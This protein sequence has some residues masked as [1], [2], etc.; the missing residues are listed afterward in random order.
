MTS[1]AARSA[2]ALLASSHRRQ[3]GDR[4]RPRRRRPVASGRAVDRLVNLQEVGGEAKPYQV[5]QF[6]KL[7][8][9]YG[10]RLEKR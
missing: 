8:E 4:R 3:R 5:R 1:N 9:R 6:L 10:V 7:V 2:P